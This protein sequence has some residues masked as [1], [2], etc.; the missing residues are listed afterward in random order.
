[1]QM[2]PA[3]HSLSRTKRGKTSRN[4]LF[5]NG[6]LD[7]HVMPFGICSE[8]IT[9][10]RIPIPDV[11]DDTNNLPFDC[12]TEFRYSGNDLTVFDVEAAMRGARCSSMRFARDLRAATAG[13]EIQIRAGIGLHH[14]LHE[15]L[16]VAAFHRIH[17]SL[18]GSTAAFQMVLGDVQM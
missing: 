17:R 14:A 2:A 16:L 15:E 11:V 5:P 1:M 12:G 13:Q 4:H 3:R 18:P 7:Q 6:A 9:V 10:P 8:A